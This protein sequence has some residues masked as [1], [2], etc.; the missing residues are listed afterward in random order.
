M[1]VDIVFAGR[2]SLEMGLAGMAG[3]GE[4]L[5]QEASKPMTRIH[6]VHEKHTTVTEYQNK[7][8]C[9]WVESA[10][11]K[12]ERKNFLFASCYVSVVF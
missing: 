2:P 3:G 4:K 6:I 8:S 11:R 10:S 7:H 5:H 12:K 9:T 1:E